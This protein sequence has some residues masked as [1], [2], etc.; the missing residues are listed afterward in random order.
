[1]IAE[2]FGSRF[3]DLE[4]CFKCLIK[5]QMHMKSKWFINA[6]HISLRDKDICNFN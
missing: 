4:F 5:I 1:M 3:S 2:L 6:F